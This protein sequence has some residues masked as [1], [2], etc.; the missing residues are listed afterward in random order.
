MFTLKQLANPALLSLAAKKAFRYLDRHS[1]YLDRADAAM[2]C[3][4]LTFQVQRLS[5]ELLAGRYSPQPKFLFAGPKAIEMTQDGSNKYIVRTFCTYPFKD[6][7]VE[8]A[9][10]CLFGDHFEDQW[11]NPEASEYPQIAAYGNRLH[12]IGEGKNVKFS[13][14]SSRLYRDWPDDYAAFVQM[15]ERA[16]NDPRDHSREAV[17]ASSSSGRAADRLA[18]WD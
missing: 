9:L 7:V 3:G 16:F 5:R 10:V 13:V 12:R 8:T 1:W 15:T 11:G 18:G 14:G 17:R 4:R 2:F 6:Q